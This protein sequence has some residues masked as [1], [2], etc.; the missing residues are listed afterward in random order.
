MHAGINGQTKKAQFFP[1]LAHEAFMPHSNLPLYVI[2]IFAITLNRL[3]GN[4][5]SFDSHDKY[6]AIGHA[7]DLFS[8]LF[9]LYSQFQPRFTISTWNGVPA[10]LYP[11]KLD[12]VE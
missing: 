9:F 2:R 11:F 4:H 3:F 1:S 8:R 6:Q 10:Y 7:T 5:L 12:P